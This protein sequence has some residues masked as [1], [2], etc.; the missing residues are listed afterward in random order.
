MRDREDGR[1]GG[2]EGT[3]E[4]LPGRRWEGRAGVGGSDGDDERGTLVAT[5]GD[6]H[7]FPPRRTGRG[8]S[9]VGEAERTFPLEWS[10]SMR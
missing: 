1:E 7:F 9:C 6:T 5:R 3:M 10:A 8:L 2:R 4:P